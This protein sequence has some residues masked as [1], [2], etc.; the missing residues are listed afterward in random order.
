M[1]PKP[2]ANN[3]KPQTNFIGVEGSIFFLAK[4][5][6]I[7]ENNGANK[8]IKNGL[9]DWKTPAGNSIPPISGKKAG[10]TLSTCLSAN[11]VKLVPACSN[12]D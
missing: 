2:N 10:N 6:H 3:A 1:K 5:I 12:A 4:L 7:L 11:I 8:I 9:N